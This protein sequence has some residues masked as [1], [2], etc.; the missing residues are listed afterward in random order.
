MYRKHFTLPTEWRGDRVALRFEGVYKSAEVWINGHI[1]KSYGG[2]AGLGGW[3]AEAYTEFE[4]RL[5]NLTSLTYGNGAKPNV[6]AIY[7]SGQPGNEHW[8]T[9]A[10]LYRSVHL[11][12]SNLLHIDPLSKLSQIMAMEA[13]L[14]ISSCCALPHSTETS[15]IR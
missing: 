3:S 2:S 1:I 4:V 5:D 15:L 8:Y 13:S 7:V 12:H 9:G 11:I 10:G 14:R 6:I